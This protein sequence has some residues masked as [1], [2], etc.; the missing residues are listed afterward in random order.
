MYTALLNRYIIQILL[1]ASVVAAGEFARTGYM[2]HTELE[3]LDS[4]IQNL[5]YDMRALSMDLYVFR[6]VNKNLE[7]IDRLANS[8]RKLSPNNFSITPFIHQ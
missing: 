3:G 7:Y 6:H 5:Q 8:E 2:L 1:A 4:R